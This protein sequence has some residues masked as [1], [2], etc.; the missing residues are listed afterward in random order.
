[1]LSSALVALAGSLP[2]GAVTLA[3]GP[4]KPF[5]TIAGAVAAAHDGDVVEVQAGTYTNDFATITRQ[6]S[7]VGVGGLARLVATIPI[8]NGKGIFVIGANAKLERLEFNGARVADR[9]GAGIRYEAGILTIKRCYF[10]NNENGILAAANAT[11]KIAITSS[12]FDGN[13]RGDGYTHGL[14]VN[15]IAELRIVGSYFHDT[16]VGHHIKSRAA[17]TIIDGNRI[18]DGTVGTASYNVDA[19]NGGAVVITNNNIVQSAAS[20]N[21]TLIHFGGESAPY[22]GSSLGVSSNIMQNFRSSAIGVLN[23]TTIPVSISNNQLYA[24]PRILSGPG[25][26]SNNVVLGAPVPVSTAPP[27]R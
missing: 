25:T 12:E 9:N 18:V 6:I 7:I 16:K 24:L 2:A 14:Y 3:V 13:G 15:K 4:G 21:A 5:A 10:K 20:Q 11:G 26:L 22:A 27:W 23:A 19:P 1:M 8:P 17:S